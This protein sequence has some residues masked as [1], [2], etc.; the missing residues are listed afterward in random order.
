MRKVFHG[1]PAP[2]G[3]YCLPFMDQGGGLEDLLLSARMGVLLQPCVSV[4][5]QS[6]LSQVR[7]LSAGLTI[8]RL[9]S[10]QRVAVAYC[11]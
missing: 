3:N 9:V 4:T 10:E 2:D 11:F 1:G 5:N 7:L 8:S 6:S